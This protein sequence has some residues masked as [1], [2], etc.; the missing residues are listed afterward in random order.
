MCLVWNV[1]FPNAEPGVQGAFCRG[2]FD[3]EESRYNIPD[4]YKGDVRIM[5]MLG[6]PETSALH[7]IIKGILRGPHMGRAMSGDHMSHYLHS[8]S[9]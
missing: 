1:G 6:I 9:G 3:N 8:L 2:L 5:F 4:S 7:E